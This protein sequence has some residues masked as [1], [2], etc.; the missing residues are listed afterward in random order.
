MSDVL[1]IQQL[2]SQG[3]HA[4]VR[5]RGVS[6][7]PLLYEG[8]SHVIVAP[9][10]GELSPGDLPLFRTPEGAYVIHRVLRR[11]GE[12][13]YTRGDN[14]F[15]GERVAAEQILGVVVEIHRKGKTIPVTHRGY[16]LYARLWPMLHP[17]WTVVMALRGRLGGAGTGEE[18]Q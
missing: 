9:V 6:M 8:R 17:L 7:Q 14:A 4:L 3:R 12:G 15:A 18:R 10:T 1:S 5:T 16:R 11:D 2:L 13:Y